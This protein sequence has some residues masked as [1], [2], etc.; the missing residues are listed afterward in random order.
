MPNSRRVSC[1]GCR[2]FVQL[3]LS[4]QFMI[5]PSI[6]VARPHAPGSIFSTQGG[7]R[8]IFRRPKGRKRD[9]PRDRP[10]SPLPP[11]CLLPRLS[12]C[13]CLLCRSPLPPMHPSKCQAR[14]QTFQTRQMVRSMRTN[15]EGRRQNSVGHGLFSGGPSVV[16]GIKVWGISSRPILRWL[17]SIALVSQAKA[18]SATR[19]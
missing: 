11:S 9:N 10:L 2:T 3:S 8:S 7:A 17:E 13:A 16:Q 14:S 12:P 1:E 19:L 6:A 15:E 18:R 4:D 5:V